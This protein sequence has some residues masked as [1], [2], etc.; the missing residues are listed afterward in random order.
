MSL[1]NVVLSP[2]SEL[3]LPWVLRPFLFGLTV[4]LLAASTWPAMKWALSDYWMDG[5]KDERRQWGGREEIGL[6]QSPR[7]SQPLGECGLMSQPHQNPG[8]WLL[9]IYRSRAELSPGGVWESL[10]HSPQRCA[11][12]SI[13]LWMTGFLGTCWL[14][15]LMIGLPKSVSAQGHESVFLPQSSKLRGTAPPFSSEAPTDV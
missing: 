10:D 8:T 11:I 1:F 3:Y 7:D 13:F 6:L 4:V 15:C 5:R 2:S 9:G 12:C 14:A